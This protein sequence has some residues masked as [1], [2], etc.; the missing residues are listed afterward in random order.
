MY[1]PMCLIRGVVLTMTGPT[2]YLHAFGSAVFWIAA[3][4]LGSVAS[5]GS[6]PT[7]QFN[8]KMGMARL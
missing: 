8:I 1:I 7:F 6:R 5:S 4:I 2:H 3:Q